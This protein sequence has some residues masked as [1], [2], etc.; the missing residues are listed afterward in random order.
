MGG[1]GRDI[2]MP[3]SAASGAASVL[4]V[5]S[6]KSDDIFVFISLLKALTASVG[7]FSSSLVFD[8]FR[9]YRLFVDFFKR[10]IGRVP[11]G[12]AV[13]GYVSCRHPAYE[14]IFVL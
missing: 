3:S 14:D 5:A 6:P 1:G 7:Y 13:N 10:E 11:H 12:D 4:V 8:A 9:E 2:R